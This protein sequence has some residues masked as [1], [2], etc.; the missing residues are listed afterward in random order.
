MPEQD[1]LADAH[2]CTVALKYCKPGDKRMINSEKG[3]KSVSDDK[4][5]ERHCRMQE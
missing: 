5:S 3:I 4:E 1:P 2:R